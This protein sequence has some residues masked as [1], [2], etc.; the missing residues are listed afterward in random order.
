M[1]IVTN[2]PIAPVLKTITVKVSV[3]RAFRIF[4][5]GFDSWWPRSHN[6]TQSTM[7]KALID[8]SGLKQDETIDDL[9]VHAALPGSW[10][11]LP[12]VK[13]SLYTH[14]Q[15]RSPSTGGSFRGGA[16]KR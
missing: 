13:A 9:K 4:T 2:A 10:E 8:F 7:E 5:E 12:P 16:G 1:T 6:I 15:W 3:E 14:A 11:A